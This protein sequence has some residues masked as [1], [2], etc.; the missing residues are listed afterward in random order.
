ME[1]LS[2]YENTP[3]RCKGIKFETGFSCTDKLENRRPFLIPVRFVVIC[4]QGH[5]SDFPFME[6]V[7]GGSEYGKDCRLRYEVRNLASPL[8]A[9]MISCSCSKKRTMVGAF[10]KD[11]LGKVGFSCY[12]E[13]PWL[14]EVKSENNTKSCP[15][16]ELHVV[17]RGASN[18]YFPDIKSSIYVPDTDEEK[19]NSILEKIAE[20]YWYKLG[21]KVDGKP[22]RQRIEQFAKSN[23]LDADALFKIIEKRMN[24]SFS[25]INDTSEEEF[26]NAEYEMFSGPE[27]DQTRDY[28][29]KKQQID[30]YDK[31]VTDFFSSITLIHKLRETRVLCGFTRWLPE[32]GKNLNDRK[33]MLKKEGSRIDWL[34]GIIVRGE[35]VF[36][37]FDRNRIKEWE[38][39]KSVIERSNLL[40]GNYNAMREAF[41]QKPRSLNARFI[42][43][44]TFAHILINQFGLSC[45]YGSASLRERIYC[46]ITERNEMNGILIYTASGDSEGSLGGL[47]S[48]SKP[49]RLEEIVLEAI[50]GAKW[51]SADP[52]CIT[53]HGQGPGSSN[54]AACHNCALLPETSCEER[55]MLLDR[56]L[57]IKSLEQPDAAFFTG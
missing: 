4:D 57:I 36:I 42:L 49:G 34:P 28:F 41:G 46:G 29:A 32:D 23:G 6:W 9:I 22:D 54:L 56:G 16:G 38:T 44:H 47:V 21:N 35:G 8:A 30:K 51:C 37:S 31:S 3:Q 43:L 19:K 11:I 25:E 45:G 20:E 7:H 14:G 52:I 2:I 5:I 39:R 13:R 24:S 10:N 48:Q 1:F 33:I 17:Q 50:A 15:K 26:R 53:S 40:I 12:G 18:V 55:N 27:G